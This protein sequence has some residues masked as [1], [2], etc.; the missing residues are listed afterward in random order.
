MSGATGLNSTFDHS[1]FLQ[2][3][4]SFHWAPMGNLGV[5]L[6]HSVLHRLFGLELE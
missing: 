3:Y 1:L 2:R 5:D 6:D 4:Y